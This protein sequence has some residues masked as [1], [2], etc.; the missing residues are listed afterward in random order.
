[1]GVDG[2][3][4]KESSRLFFFSFLGF[5]FSEGQSGQ[6]AP[7]L[8]ILSEFAAPAQRAVLRRPLP[9]PGELVPRPGAPAVGGA[10]PATPFRSP[11]PSDA[12]AAGR[13]PGRAGGRPGGARGARLEGKGRPAAAR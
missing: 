13:L 2:A 3:H 12:A 6:T 7:R 1:M 11:E 8:G 10:A 5:C 9:R 4:A